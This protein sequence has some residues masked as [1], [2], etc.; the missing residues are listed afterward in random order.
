MKEDLEIFFF[1]LT[2]PQSLSEGEH[3]IKRHEL[4]SS[5]KLTIFSEAII[6]QLQNCDANANFTVLPRELNEMASI[7]TCL[8][9]LLN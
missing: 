2:G 9:R 7:E 8:E 5:E 1:N 3:D 6:P 4:E